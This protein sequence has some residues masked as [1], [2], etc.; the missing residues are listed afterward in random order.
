MKDVAYLLE[1]LDVDKSF[2]GVKALDHARLQVRPGT[3]HALMGENGAGKS[4][5]IKIISGVQKPDE[6]GEI[7]VEGRPVSFEGAKDSIELGINAIYQDLSLFPN[8]TVAENIYLGHAKG[9]VNWK[10][11]IRV[12]REVLE[13]LEMDIDVHA[14]LNK[15]SI[16]KQQ[17]VAI[18]RDLHELTAADHG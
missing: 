5:L 7:L 14:Q 12:A 18:A 13:R 8:L 11:C 10:D 4:T 3:V 9:V 1:M 16:A 6:G 2:P 17:L 15:L